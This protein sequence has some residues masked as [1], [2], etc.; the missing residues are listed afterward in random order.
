V[1][2]SSIII[3]S[4]PTSKIAA[5]IGASNGPANSGAPGQNTFAQALHNA[6]SGQAQT[7]DKS[8]PKGT[9]SGAGNPSDKKHA[10]PAVGT[11][12]GFSVPVI[13]LQSVAFAAPLVPIVSTPITIV[14]T[15]AGQVKS[16]GAP[17]A[18]DSGVN[19]AAPSATNLP[20][21]TPDFVNASTNSTKQAAP[22]LD[23]IGWNAKFEGDQK[24]SAEPVNPITLPKNHDLISSGT[25]AS[26]HAS[27][28]SSLSN[29]ETPQVQSTL[30][31]TGST[32]ANVP[33]IQPIAAGSEADTTT[34][35]TR[36][37]D[38][39]F[40]DAILQNK[41]L[42]LLHLPQV[43]ALQVGNGEVR[44]PRLPVSTA[45]HDSQA[46]SSSSQA[47]S[48]DAAAQIPID[49]SRLVSSPSFVKAFPSSVIP[50]NFTSATAVQGIKRLGVNPEPTSSAKNSADLH[51]IA[52]V[53][54]S[55]TKNPSS[56]DVT[57][58]SSP[59]T[60]AAL[61]AVQS[62]DAG[63]STNAPSNVVSPLTIPP[64]GILD[65]AVSAA[66]SQSPAPQ[67]NAPA[68][69]PVL[70]RGQIQVARIVNGLIQSEMHIGMRTQA[71]GSVEV[72]TVVRDAQ[73]GLA[74]GSEKGDLKTFL[75]SE[76]SSLQTTFRQQ[77]LRFENIR[78][79]SSGTGM[80]T[81]TQSGLSNG[82]NSQPQSSDHR[83]AVQSA[84][85]RLDGPESDNFE[86]VETY[87]VRAGINL[88]A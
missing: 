14:P 2:A 87:D 9:T 19:G 68:E 1:V 82:A 23:G 30:A 27:H 5:N 55:S 52:N 74:I 13:P 18:N 71:F 50:K 54:H 32:A 44:K 42:A 11:L 7:S 25:V 64:K 40:Q 65:P 69:L 21:S 72:H 20:G 39:K 38:V 8:K 83:H 46:A 60:A 43:Q 80:H 79:L 75:T 59:T 17:L 26:N 22:G 12:P 58:L 73:V 35:D 62:S 24:T 47:I 4:A 77:D 3:D 15:T 53:P 16:I 84:L 67:A 31:L 86:T 81:G 48:Q 37:Q 49:A 41:E 70:P 56:S 45:G 36:L 51:T 85:F 61:L 88:H 6:D 34:R 33:V 63:S 10:K 57:S 78:F 76:V 29:G 28:A 66:K